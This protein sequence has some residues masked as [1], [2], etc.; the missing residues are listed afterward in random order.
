[1]AYYFYMDA[2]SLAKR[3]TPEIGS[4][5]VDEILESVSGRRFYILNISAG[6]IMSILVRKKNASAISGSSFSQALL[7]FDAEIVRSTAVQKVTVSNGLATASFALIVAHSINSTDAVIMQSALAIAHRLRAKGNDL[8]LVASDQRLL[9]AAQ[10][11]GLSTFDPE[12]QDQA[13][14]VA[15]VGP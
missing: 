9:R 6:E 8:V 10:A 15:F 1:L 13:A 3:Y 5:L 12:I 7:D 14:L 4:S 2:S 11:E